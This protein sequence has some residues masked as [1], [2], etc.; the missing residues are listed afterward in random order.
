MEFFRTATHVPFM[1]MRKWA[2]LASAILIVASLAAVTLDGLNLAVDFT[3]GTTM[4][5]QF[6]AAADLDEIR[7]EL[8]RA[9]FEDAQTSIFGTSRDIIVR[10]PPVQGRQDGARIRAEVEKVLKRVDPNAQVVRLD[11][12]GPQVGAELRQSAYWSFG[13]AMLL[14]FLYVLLRFHTWKLSLAAILATLY[15]PVL[16]LGFFAVTGMSFDL[17]VVA[18]ILAVIGYSLN[19]KV[20]IF[21]RIRERFEINRRASPTQVLDESINQTLS[22]TLMTA[23]STLLVLISLYVLGGAVLQQFAAAMLIGVALGHFSSIFVASALALDFGVHAED[24]FPS[25]KKTAAD[26][27]P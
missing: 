19:D 13:F 16:V 23:I 11:A 26:T 2:Y 25:Q 1:G 27:L 18:A 5:A 10:M 7:A 6:P 24:I 4:E 9:G 21:D 15:D 14:I 22:R 20:V 8:G 17:S 3:G 12:V